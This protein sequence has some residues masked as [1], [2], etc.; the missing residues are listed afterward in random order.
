MCFQK[1]RVYRF[2]LPR[3]G[4]S[5]GLVGILHDFYKVT[6]CFVSLGA[7]GTVGTYL[8]LLRC[9]LIVL[10][11][12]KSLVEL[13]ELHDILALSSRVRNSSCYQ[14]FQVV[15]HFLAHGDD[16]D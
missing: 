4:V 1:F 15:E 12:G 5:T 13:L 14:F 9:F 6:N 7:L 8:N 10:G 3:E 16:D 11:H 2:S